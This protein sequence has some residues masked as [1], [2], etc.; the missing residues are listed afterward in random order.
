MAIILILGFIMISIGIK[1]ENF[2]IVSKIIL[3][4]AL[5]ILFINFIGSGAKY[6]SINEEDTKTPNYKKELIIS[7]I[8]YFI[9]ETIGYFIYFNIIPLIYENTF[10]LDNI[11][12]IDFNLI[13]VIIVIL[14]YIGLVREDWFKVIPK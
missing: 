7:T 2:P 14:S 3:I 12:N 10:I 13:Y 5:M 6:E 4:L 8:G 9:M 11:F 1:S